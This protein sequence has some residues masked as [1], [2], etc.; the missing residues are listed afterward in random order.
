MSL[1]CLKASEGLPSPQDEYQS[2]HDSLQS[3]DLAPARLS[4]PAHA[5]HT[6]LVHYTIAMLAVFLLLKYASWSSLWAYAPA[7]PPSLGHFTFDLH[8][9]LALA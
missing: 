6:C 9:I 8:I 4:T 7:I 1:T 2:F 5:P 3:P